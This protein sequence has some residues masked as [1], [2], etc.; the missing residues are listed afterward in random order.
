[1]MVEKD[2]ED[3][4]YPDRKSAYLCQELSYMLK[5]FGF[6]N[7][8]VRHSWSNELFILLVHGRRALKKHRDEIDRYP[9]WGN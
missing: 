6:V 8:V 9:L 3:V 4:K 1:M 5:R 7:R 2:G